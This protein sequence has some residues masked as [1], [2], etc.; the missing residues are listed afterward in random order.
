MTEP[1]RLNHPMLLTGLD[2]LFVGCLDGFGQ[3]CLDHP[4]ELALPRHPYQPDVSINGI[5]LWGGGNSDIY[6]RWSGENDMTWIRGFPH[7]NVD[8]L[9]PGQIVSFKAHAALQG[10]PAAARIVYLHG[11]PKMHELMHLP[12]VRE[13]WR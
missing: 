5:S 13:A 1:Y 9:W 6:D 8:V 10:L 11:T 7:E 4:R 12:W 2:T 3:W